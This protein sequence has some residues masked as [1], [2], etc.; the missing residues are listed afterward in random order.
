MTVSTP[1]AVGEK[2]GSKT[3]FPSGKFLLVRV[4]LAVV[5][6]LRDCDRWLRSH[7]EERTQSFQVLCHG[8]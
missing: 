4:Y 6:F 8:S 3:R 2:L 7:L 5:C 1:T